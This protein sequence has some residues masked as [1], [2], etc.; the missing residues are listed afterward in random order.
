[1]K[2][3]HLAAVPRKVGGC[4]A[5]RVTCRQKVRLSS[6]ASEQPAHTRAP[7]QDSWLS[8]SQDRV[9]HHSAGARHACERWCARPGSVQGCV[10]NSR[11]RKDSPVRRYIPS[12]ALDPRRRV[13]RRQARYTGHLIAVGT[14][15]TSVTAP[16]LERAAAP[17]SRPHTTTRTFNWLESAS[18]VLPAAANA[19]Q[20]GSRRACPEARAQTCAETRLSAQL[21][22]RGSETCSH[23]V[24]LM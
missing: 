16:C 22:R 4:V 13:G 18:V 24:L 6:G 3:T 9:T 19:T 17:T 23:R 14:A 2:H 12:P 10:V 7:S 15:T 21:G 8:E 20:L 11:R 5:G 1:M